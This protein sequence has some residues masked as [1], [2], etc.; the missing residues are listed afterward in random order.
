[1]YKATSKTRACVAQVMSDKKANDITKKNA[2]IDVHSEMTMM[3]PP[4]ETR[5]P[6]AV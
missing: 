4:G 5:A 2:K 1:M 6:D 3:S